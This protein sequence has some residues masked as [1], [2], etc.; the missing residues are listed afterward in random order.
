MEF[1]FDCES[2]FKPDSSGMVI[3]DAQRDKPLGRMTPKIQQIY[4]IIDKMGAASAKV[5]KFDIIILSKIQSL[6]IHL[7]TETGWSYHYSTK[8]LLQ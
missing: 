8:I 5:Y 1:L 7:G 6:N 4:D 3:L 2:L